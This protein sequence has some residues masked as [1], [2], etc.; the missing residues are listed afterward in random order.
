MLE[1]A[2]AALGEVPARRLLVVRPGRER[3]VIEKSIARDPER[4]VPA[5]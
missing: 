2:P 5:A 1:L 3:T 4:D